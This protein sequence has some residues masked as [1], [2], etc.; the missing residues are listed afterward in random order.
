[1]LATTE[2]ID[3]LFEAYIRRV[4]SIDDG[5]R[6]FLADFRLRANRF[7]VSI[8]SIVFFDCLRRLKATLRVTKGAAALEGGRKK[9]LRHPAMV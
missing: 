6:D 9:G 5:S 1:M 8:P 3:R 7:L 2:R 4:V